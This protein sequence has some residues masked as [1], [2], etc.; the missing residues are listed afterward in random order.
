MW[1]WGATA[2]CLGSSVAVLAQAHPCT[3]Q[4]AQRADQAVDTLNSWNRIYDWYKR[5]RQCDDGGPAEGVSEAVARNFDRWET[6]PRLAELAKN[7]AGFRR[8]VLKHVDE[9]L[10]G[11]DLKK[12]S[13]NTV[14]RCPAN[15]HSLCRELKMQAEAP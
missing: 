6:L 14:N 9:T 7:D 4:D 8:F 11:D 10:N 13:A 15:L 1:R 2:L 12:I 5:Y 3:Q